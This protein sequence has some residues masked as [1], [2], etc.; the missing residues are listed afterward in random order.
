[1]HDT[2]QA[3]DGNQDLTI[4][5]LH[6][7]DLQHKLPPVS[8]TPALLP[9]DHQRGAMRSK[10]MVRLLQM[11]CVCMRT[12]AC[13]MCDGVRMDTYGF[14]HTQTN[15]HTNKCTHKKIHT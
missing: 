5:A 7:L 14:G 3:Y 2:L 8:V 4:N 12:W 15:A 6:A 9:T 1:M 13:S 10:A 11:L